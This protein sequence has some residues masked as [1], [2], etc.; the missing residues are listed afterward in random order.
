MDS[1]KYLYN[2]LFTTE[3]G[4]SLL[5]DLAIMLGLH[6]SPLMPNDPLSTGEKIGKQNA[7]RDLLSLI[8]I[9]ELEV[10]TRIKEELKRS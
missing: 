2:Q 3:N 9:N 10:L 7:M 1:R 5:V 6:K 4:M 8:N